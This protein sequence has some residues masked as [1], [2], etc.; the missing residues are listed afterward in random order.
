M[1][2]S[3]CQLFW[4]RAAGLNRI[5]FCGANDSRAFG[6]RGRRSHFAEKLEQLTKSCGW[7]GLARSTHRSLK[8]VLSGHKLAQHSVILLA[9]CLISLQAFIFRQ[10]DLF[11]CFRGPTPAWW[12]PAQIA[13]LIKAD[14]LDVGI[15]AQSVFTHCGPRTLARNG[16]LKPKYYPHVTVCGA[17][18]LFAAPLC[19]VLSLPYLRATSEF[20]DAAFADAVIDA[21]IA[22]ES[23]VFVAADETAAPVDLTAVPKLPPSDEPT[24]VAMRPSENTPTVA[25]YDHPDPVAPIDD[26]AAVRDMA[27]IETSAPPAESSVPI[28]RMAKSQ[29]LEPDVMGQA[30]IK[31]DMP[32]PEEVVSVDPAEAREEEFVEPKVAAGTHFDATSHL[33]MR[34][35]GLG[36]GATANAMNTSAPDNRNNR[37]ADSRTGSRMSE[38][39]KRNA[40]RSSAGLMADVIPKEGTFG[41]SPEAVM[42]EVILQQPLESR[43]VG[44][45]ENVVAVTRAQGW[46]VALVKSDLPDDQ[47]WVQQMVGIRGNAFAARVNFGNEH[48]IRGSVYHLVFVFL[49]SPDEVRRFRI[50]KQFRKLPEGIRRSREYTFTRR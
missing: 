40:E 24:R 32:E 26:A 10:K 49:D 2:I 34:D 38:A 37:V 46:P 50:A 36:S 39:E 43:T 23:A 31:P 17:A 16:S 33:A 48:S 28:P 25:E 35:G 13:S 47:W 21:T 4:P 7:Y 9:Q 42:E 44:R 14:S 3:V 27:S 8:T 11:A 6:S 1:Q 30:V 29:L 5:G 19:F 20:D 22:D 12:F 15:F 41:E 18:V 45:M